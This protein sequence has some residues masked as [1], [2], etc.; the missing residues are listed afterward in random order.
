MAKLSWAAYEMGGLESVRIPYEGYFDPE[1]WGGELDKWK[2]N[3]PV[4]KK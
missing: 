2:D 1:I 3:I 4:L